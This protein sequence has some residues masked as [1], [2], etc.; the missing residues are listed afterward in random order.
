MVSSPQ[1]PLLASLAGCWPLGLRISPESV[2]IA[3]VSSVSNRLAPVS[4]RIAPE[5]SRIAPYRTVSRPDRLVSHR[6]APSRIVSH[7][8]RIVSLGSSRTGSSRTG[9]SRAGIESS[10]AVASP[11]FSFAPVWKFSFLH[12]STSVA[13]FLFLAQSA[14]K[15]SLLLF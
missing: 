15:S 14:S 12:L 1:A 11:K 9:S 8:N 10:R 4:N 7:R 3:L 6:I 13:T 2:R 5:S